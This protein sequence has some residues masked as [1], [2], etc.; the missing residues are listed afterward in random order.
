MVVSLPVSPTLTSYAAFHGILVVLGVADAPVNVFVGRCRS[1][2]WD[3][4]YREESAIF[5]V[6]SHV[7]LGLVVG[8][9]RKM[10]GMREADVESVVG[11][12]GGEEVK[13]DAAGT[14]YQS[15]MQQAF[16]VVGV[17]YFLILIDSFYLYQFL[18]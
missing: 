5:H 8:D 2:A 16:Q 6:L 14:P 10:G 17:R 15:S 3:W 1:I 4:D 11:K 13:V 9:D 18:G 7:W 12:D